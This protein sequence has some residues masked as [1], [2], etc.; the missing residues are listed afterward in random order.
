LGTPAGDALG[1]WCP[2]GFNS[3]SN[4]PHTGREEGRGGNLA[5]L[6]QILGHADIQTTQRYARLTDEHVKA[7]AERLDEAI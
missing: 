3:R 1:G 5:T 4:E 7:E 2:G 6:Q